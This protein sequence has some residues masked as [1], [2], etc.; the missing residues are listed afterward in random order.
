M[1]WAESQA[2]QPALAAAPHPAW[3]LDAL[4]AGM[5][6]LISIPPPKLTLPAMP[7]PCTKHNPRV[8]FCAQHLEQQQHFQGHSLVSASPTTH[9]VHEKTTSMISKHPGGNACCRTDL[10]HKLYPNGEQ[11][12]Q[13]HFSKEHL[14][15]Q[16]VGKA[17]NEKEVQGGGRD[18]LAQPM[19]HCY[20]RA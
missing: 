4:P 10:H 15:K 18:P 19:R 8:H 17:S 6:N 7:Q 13:N 11:R 12:C 9:T 20:H 2:G 16:E 3:L 1:P 5:F 14:E